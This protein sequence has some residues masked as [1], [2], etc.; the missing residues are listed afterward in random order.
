MS[1]RS[2]LR[3]L[4]WNLVHRRRVERDL[5]DEV[6]TAFE[7]LVAER[8]R[9][10]MSPADARRAA[11]IE[12]GR[13][14]A[15][16]QHVRDV[17]AGAFVSACV[18]DV[19]YGARLLLRNPLFALTATVSLAVG[20]G[21]NT[22]IFSL[23]NVLMLRDLRVAD[24]H[25][26]VE[27]GRI[28]QY[29]RGGSFSYPIYT[30]L[31]DENAV[32][33]GMLTMSKSTVEATGD[34]AAR[35][36]A[37]RYVSGNFFDVLGVSPL[38]G[39]LLSPADDRA[40]APDGTAVTVI[41]Y[42][43]WQR[44]FGGS[45]EALGKRIMVD[46]V[47]FLI[48]GVLPPAFD[49]LVLGR[50]ADFF[51]PVASQSQLR[52]E[53]WLDKPDFNWLAIVGRLNPGTSIE[54]VTVNLDQIFSRFLED[55]ATTMKDADA[56]QT[57]RAQRL[58]LESAR[59]GLS[60]LRRQFSKPVLLLMGAVSFVLLI[61]CANVVNLLLAR[62]VGRRREIALRLAI[63]ASR[64]R[65]IRQLLTESALLG[66]IGGGLGLLLA[67]WGAPLLATLV[68]QNGSPLDLDLAPDRQI[69]LFTATLALGTS[70]LAGVLPALRT[71]RTDITPSFQGDAR[72]LSIT[73]A[74]T[75][76]GQALIAAQVALSLMLVVG[77]SLLVAT[78][79]NFRDF[80]PG[81]DREH[82]LLL[83]LNPAKAGYDGAR[84]TQYYGEVLSRVRATPGVQA[85][86]LSVITPISGGGIDL[87]FAVDGQ[88]RESRAT[89]YVNQVSDGFFATMG[90]PLLL[91]H[92]FVAR[93]G[94]GR[95]PSAV[96]ND[97]LARRYFKGTHPIGQRVTLGDQPG[98]EIVGVVASAK[99]LSLREND[100]PT[101]YVYLQ[102]ERGPAG[103]ALSVRTFGDPL[104]SAA[105][106]RRAV[107]SVAA[108]VPVSPAR[109]LSS[110]VDRSLV[111]E[112]L[113]A[114][115][116][117][118][119][120]FLALLLASVGLYGVLGYS[121][122]RRT[123]EI[124]VRLALGATRGAVL[125]SVL[126]ES[127]LLVAIGSAIGV[128][129]SMTLSRLLSTLLYGVTPSDPKVL[130]GAVSCLFLVALSAASLPAW[131]ASRV[132]P[133]VALRHE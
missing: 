9:T 105:A 107:Q 99:Y 31:R 39:R 37:G 96:I 93:D 81:F 17:R 10:G 12:L 28:T 129:A 53:S 25:Q 4:W 24:P 116:L 67:A 130:A 90:T 46:S 103:L 117:T 2:R 83:N 91:G 85:A 133:L 55:Y 109:T 122:A 44:E 50:P 15:I 41:D 56:R 38:I 76:W 48:V 94:V 70:L 72:S 120:A 20:I 42:G 21:A 71:A 110:Q 26:L 87:P 65:L 112:R 47:A 6:R 14:E 131:R 118:T 86:S 102:D 34:S 82:V 29:G 63:G 7:L 1:L 92:D 27:I 23:V 124:G 89:V 5:D 19:R 123:G 88:P 77:A 108:S 40:D 59:S 57:F 113:V 98:F 11:T 36:A 61:A 114:R 64:G 69:L 62:G 84:L 3:S 35:Q 66:I 49:D 18:Q 52:R 100:V 33:S 58:A 80:D 128:P 30:R 111:T 75:R 101:I 119:F 54:A 97:A 60:D 78:L 45:P 73:R 32:F 51:I 95:I 126:R 127:W 104:S 115:L 106:I 13:I 79:R 43:L 74:S 125:R 121:V 22:A 132:D 16:K 68:A 8:I